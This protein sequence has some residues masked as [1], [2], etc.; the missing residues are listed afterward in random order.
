MYV[1]HTY[2]TENTH[3]FLSILTAPATKQFC[4]LHNTSGPPPKYLSECPARTIS[5]AS[6]LV[7][8]PHLF[9]VLNKAVLQGYK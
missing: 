6:D 7:G 1:Y 5:R 4:L 9:R 2:T 8:S 3:V